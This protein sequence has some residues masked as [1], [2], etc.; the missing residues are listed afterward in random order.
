LVAAAGP[1]AGAATTPSCLTAMG[2]AP[3]N[4]VR[5]ATLADIAAVARLSVAANRETDAELPAL[6]GETELSAPEIA[7]RLLDDLDDGEVLY[8]AERDR[9][10]AGFAHVSGLMV[11]DGGHL[12]EVRRVYVA[13]GFR[14]RGLARQLVRLIQ[15]DLSRRPNPPALRA[16]AAVDTVAER[17][18]EAVG[19][20]AVRP[21]WKVGSAGVAVRGVV[22]GWGS[23]QLQTARASHRVPALRS[24]AFA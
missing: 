8:V 5:R 15:R 22:Y 10:V 2:L 14:R 18:L 24:R 7:L 6:Q 23:R 20:T 13:Q 21:R 9:R 4:A 17:F 19:A 12:V 3:P 16:W 1:P 11:S